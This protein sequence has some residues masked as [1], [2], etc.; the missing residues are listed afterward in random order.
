MCL[1]QFNHD[2]WESEEEYKDHFQKIVSQREN[3][4][5]H[6]H[7]KSPQV[8]VACLIKLL[9]LIWHLKVV[10]QSAHYKLFEEMCSE[11]KTDPLLSAFGCIPSGH[12]YGQPFHSTRSSASGSKHVF[13]NS[14]WLH[15]VIDCNNDDLIII[16]AK[17]E[18][19]STSIP[20]IKELNANVDNAYPA[21]DYKALECIILKFYNW[22]VM[23]PT[24]AH[25]VSYFLR[26]LIAEDD[27]TRVNSPRTLLYEM[28]LVIRLLMD[29]TLDGRFCNRVKI[30]SFNNHFLCYR[31]SLY[32]KI[33]SFQI[34]SG[35]YMRS[36]EANWTVQLEFATA[37]TDTILTK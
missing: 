29:K 12:I 34:G 21:R 25:Y 31:R 11:I 8:S 37:T 5:L 22:Y 10:V 17:F 27:M 36:K 33:C 9:I 19:I 1:S 16:L 32:T 6:Y 28:H 7:H 15:P 18:E 13:V 14:R 30:M 3:C 20:K 23:F 4:R 24:V 35:D 26:A 2:V